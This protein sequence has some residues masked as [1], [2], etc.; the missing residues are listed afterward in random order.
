MKSLAPDFV[1]P[2]EPGFTF[3]AFRLE[4]D[5][6][7]LHQDAHVHVPPKELAALRLLLQNAG[8]IVTP[9]Q[10]REA[11]WGEVH[12]TEDSIPRCISSLRARLESEE[13]IQTIYKRGYRLMWPVH[14]SDA[15]T[16][17][18]LPRLAIVPF[19]GGTNVPE[20]LGQAVA[21]EATARL[22]AARPQVFSML[23]RD[24]VFALTAQ[25]MSAQQ[26]GE[27]LKADLVLTGT[28]Q[29]LAS[30]YRLR[31][32]MVRIQDGTQIWVE[33]VLVAQDQAAGL[34]S[35]LV[36]RLMFRAGCE[37]ALPAAQDAGIDPHAYDIFLRGRY[38]WQTLD[39]H[40]MQE[41]MRHLHHA[42][43]LDPNLTQAHAEL[44]RA[45]I[46]QELFGFM[47]PAT[48]AELVRSFAQRLPAHSVEHDAILPGLGWIAFHVDRD[49]GAA[50]RAFDRGASLPFD[51]WRARMR[52]LLA[53]SR[54]RFDEALDLLQASLKVD[55][56]SPWINA[57]LAW[58]YH[59]AGNAPQSVLQIE[60]CLEHSADHAATRVFG[61]II[62]AFNGDVRRA[63]E[64]TTG[65]ERQAPYFDMATAVR[66]YALACKGE[67]EQAEEWLERLQ[68][69][70]R[71]RYMMRS[72]TAAAYVALGDHEGAMA[73]LRAANEE[74]CPWFF[75]MLADPCLGALR[76]IPEFRQMRALLEGMESA[77]EPHV[78]EAADPDAK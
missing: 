8:K 75:Q 21:E 27:A 26:V 76:E 19:A 61:G 37:S 20:H 10:L 54:H 49:L 4:P 18:I 70:A 33:D 25:H 46:A 6:T 52:G 50:L 55:P 51:P 56:Y 29:A 1:V 36:E 65:L 53:A 39:R 38:E 14:R 11:L 35:K 3:G 16:E 28:V 71:E 42:A 17:S 15:T 22:T 31:A 7:L 2:V 74:R 23:A 69:L 34:E 66:A 32:E 43:E 59:L 12:V 63:A 30:K 62:L 77:G 58:V 40:R 44:V 5:G 45:C 13:C 64:L 72:F 57:S 41:G 9:K 68:W 67:R 73:E 48:A 78:G 47:S 60:R 24:S